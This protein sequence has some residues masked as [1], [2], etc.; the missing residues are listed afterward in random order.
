MSG[1]GN[2]NMAA[3]ASQPTPTYFQT[4]YYKVSIPAEL[5]LN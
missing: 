5:K 4:Y 1:N 3:K 2:T